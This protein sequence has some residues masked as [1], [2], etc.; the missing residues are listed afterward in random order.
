MAIICDVSAWEYLRTPPIVQDV[1]LTPELML[2]FTGKPP[3]KESLSQRSNAR[4]AER[5]I[6]SRLL[7]DLKGI[8]LPVHVMMDENCGNYRS[9]LIHPHRIPRDLP[10]QSLTELGGGL[11]VLPPE[12]AVTVHSQFRSPIQ[13]SKMM[14]EACGLFSVC[15]QTNRVKLALRLLKESGGIAI[16]AI[17][18][19]KVIYA[20]YGSN[21][22]RLPF[23]D[24]EGETL[25][26][27]PCFNSSGAL[28]TLWKRPPLT[29]VDDLEIT[30]S[31][32]KGLRYLRSSRE[33]LKLTRDGA[34]SPA[35]VQASLL[36]CGDARYGGEG[37]GAQQVQLNRVVEFDH[38]AKDLAG[39]AFAVADFLWPG[40]R[41]ILEVNG[42]DFHSDK[43]GFF[44][45][46]GRTPALKSLGNAVEEI[47]PSQMRDPELL[48]TMCAVIAKNLGLPLQERTA[49]FIKQRR[50]LHYELFEQPFEPIWTGARLRKNG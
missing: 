20:Y 7:T 44:L 47:T 36:F 39:I 6:G 27:A 33:G 24:E 4:E 45:D 2:A 14:H 46:T 35:E 16:D 9:A 31:K 28:T 19:S 10:L 18:R 48:E 40:L 21:G 3:H 50:N 13:I 38:A 8:S 11:Y 29:C 25:P 17:P 42:K 43:R 32:L 26:W 23:I 49:S 22:K 1:E 30:L 5:L 41:S 37:W 12:L 15:P 34:A